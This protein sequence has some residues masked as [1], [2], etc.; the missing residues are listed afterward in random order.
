MKMDV[1]PGAVDF[2]P[3]AGFFDAAGLGLAGG[4]EGLGE[5]DVGK[6]GGFVTHEAD[7]GAGHG[8]ELGGLLR[9]GRDIEVV[10]MEIHARDELAAGFGLEATDRGVAQRFVRPPIAVDDGGEQLLVEV[11][12]FLGDFCGHFLE[13]FRGQGSGVRGQGKRAGSA[14]GNGRLE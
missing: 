10:A 12:E 11:E 7:V 9:R 3:D 4:V 6:D 5:A 2:L 13:G 14:L 1:F 8:D